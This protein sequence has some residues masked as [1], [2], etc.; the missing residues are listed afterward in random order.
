MSMLDQTKGAGVYPCS[1]SWPCCSKY[2][3]SCSGFFSKRLSGSLR[4]EPL[5]DVDNS[6]EDGDE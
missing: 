6:V 1:P 5:V 2:A 3:R 4:L